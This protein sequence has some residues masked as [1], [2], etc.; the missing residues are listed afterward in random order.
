MQSF[1]DALEKGHELGVRDTR[2]FKSV[3]DDAYRKRN[4]AAVESLVIELKG[5]V[6]LV[7]AGCVFPIYDFIGNQLQELGTQA[8][9]EPLAINLLA[10]PIGG[11][12][13][14]S[15]LR[16]YSRAPRLLIDSLINNQKEIP[17]RVVKLVYASIEN[18]FAAP[19]WWE[20]LPDESRQRLI[21]LVSFGAD[22]V[23][24]VPSSGLQDDDHSYSKQVLL[25]NPRFA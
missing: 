25:N 13:V 7:A 9:P 24:F 21:E 6:E 18:A 2:F 1:L 4:F 11:V 22:P 10:A 14:L 20:Q 16:A 17:N 23:L 12:V 5:Q 15:W 8:R 3:L 19:S